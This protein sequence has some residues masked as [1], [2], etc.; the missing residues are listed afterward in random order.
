MKLPSGRGKLFIELQ[1]GKVEDLATDPPEAETMSDEQGRPAYKYTTKLPA[2]DA[3]DRKARLCVKDS[4]SKPSHVISTGHIKGCTDFIPI[5]TDALTSTAID[6]AAAERKATKE[7]TKSK[8]FQTIPRFVKSNKDYKVTFTLKDKVPKGRIEVYLKP[9]IRNAAKIEQ[10]V[11][12]P[13]NDLKTYAV[14]FKTNQIQLS[15]RNVEI[16]VR[17]RLPTMRFKMEKLLG[18]S[19]PIAINEAGGR[20]NGGSKMQA[21]PDSEGTVPLDGAGEVSPNAAETDDEEL[22]DYKPSEEVK[23]NLQNLLL[24]D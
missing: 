9:E 3:K 6:K 4:K 15:L 8:I 10:E 22:A 18:C 1:N 20:S 13:E 2:F 12:N 14:Y 21:I 17:D 19:S 11:L 16:C 7:D 23:Q 5:T 24:V